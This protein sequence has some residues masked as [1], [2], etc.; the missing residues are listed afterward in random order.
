MALAA[1]RI[2][3]LATDGVNTMHPIHCYIGMHLCRASMCERCHIDQTIQLRLNLNAGELCGVLH[4]NVNFWSQLTG[5]GH[6]R[7][8]AAVAYRPPVESDNCYTIN[9]YDSWTTHNT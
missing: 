7:H 8:C 6:V 1:Q 5:S 9:H 4:L 3:Q 2:E